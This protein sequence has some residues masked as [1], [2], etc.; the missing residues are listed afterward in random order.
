MESATALEQAI[1]NRDHRHRRLSV[2]RES[3]PAGFE[4]RGGRS[5]H[6]L[7]DILVVVVE[8]FRRELVN[9]DVMPN[10]WQ[11]AQNGVYCQSHFS[12]GNA[13]N[14]GMF[15]LMNGLEAVWYQRP[16]RFSPLMNRL[17]RS[18]GYEMGFF[19]G[20][21]QWREFYMDGYISREHFDHFEV[22]PADGLDSDRRATLLASMF[23]DRKDNPAPPPSTSGVA[24]DVDPPRFALL[25]LYATHATY[26][27]YS[28]DQVFQ[29]A[30]DD[31]FLYPYPRSS[32]EAVWNRYA[33]SARTVDRFLGAV[34]REDR[35]IVV[36][37]D[38]GESFLDDG[39]IGHGIRISEFQNM[40][41]AV[42]Y[43]PSSEPRM[44]ESPT[45][46]ADLLPTLLS[47]A[48]LSLDD[49]SAIDG[50]DLRHQTDQA[51][52]SRVLATRNYLD[53]DVALVGP[54]TL[55]PDNPFAYRIG[56]SGGASFRPIGAIDAFGN[57][58][59]TDPDA[60]SGA[61][62]RWL[63]AKFNRQPRTTPRS[64]NQ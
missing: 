57:P 28:E 8:S 38:H 43:I 46:H 26:N 64:A 32:R 7:P 60:V 53:H 13:T 40:T 39:T 61:M 30:A 44:I 19:A 24:A 33:N 12:G 58:I 15:S 45:T 18:A 3:P 6:R 34:M 63:G 41:P 36:T 55:D 25:Y 56:L 16:V 22:A 14:H 49:P 31:R 50:W 1:E 23:L 2:L 37:G 20:H 62:H 10:L 51:L 27:S 52:A 47:A 17:L 42:V 11:Y 5:D 48:G 35:L 4:S 21:D 9:A 59:E 29:P 54:W